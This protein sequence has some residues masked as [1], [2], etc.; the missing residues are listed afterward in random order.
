MFLTQYMQT[1]NYIISIILPVVDILVGEV[2]LLAQEHREFVVT[3][4]VK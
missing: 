2:L 3:M 1:I 4:M